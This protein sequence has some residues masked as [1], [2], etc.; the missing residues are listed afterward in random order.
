MAAAVLLIDIN[1]RLAKLEEGLNQA[2]RR[3]GGFKST[4]DS[5]GNSLKNAFGAAS[6]TAA[7]GKFVLLTKAA[8]DSADHL[9]DLS[10]T[11]GIAVETLGGIGFAA[12]Q[13]GSSLDAIVGPIGKLNLEIAKAAQG[14]PEAAATFNALK[15]SVRDGTGEIKNAGQVLV[16]IAGKFETFK[17]GPNKAALAN[18]LFKKGFAELVP[19]LNEGSDALRANIAYFE[20]YSGLTADVAQKADKFNDEL[21]KV[22]LLTSAFFRH[23][24]AELLPTLTG[25]AQAMSE[26]KEKNGGFRDEAAKTAEVI[27]NL[28]EW[29]FTGST[30]FQAFAT[31]LGGGAAQLAAIAVGDFARARK[32]GELMIEDLAKVRKEREAFLNR[33]NNPLPENGPKRPPPINAPGLPNSDGAKKILD[34]Q[35]KAFEDSIRDE[36]KL[37]S[38]RERFLQTYYADD[39][40]SIR[41]FFG[42]RQTIIDLALAKELEAYDGEIAA[43]T[44]GTDRV[45]AE[46]DIAAAI[47]KRADAQQAAAT[48]SVGLFFEERRALKA[49]KED[50]EQTSIRLLDLSGDKVGAALANFDFGN[51]Q[52]TLRINLELGSPDADTRRIAEISQ[53]ALETE[54]EQVKVQAQLTDGAQRFGD[55]LEQV[56]NAQARID[57]A[58]STGSL[59]ELEALRATGDANTAR[60]A[61]LRQ[62][63]DAY[64]EIAD[65]SSDPRAQL[66]ADALRL[67]IEQ[68]AAAGDLVAKK[69]NDVFINSFADAIESAT[70][71]GAKL[72]DILKNLEKSLVSGIS[73]IASQNIAETIFKPENLGGLGKIFGGL[74]G[75]KPAEATGAAALTGAGTTLTTAGTLLTTA[76]TQLLAAATAMQASSLAS[77]IGGGFPGFGGGFGGGSLFGGFGDAFGFPGF[78]TGTDFAP[79]GLAMVGE[80]GRELVQLPR[81]SRVI[82]NERLGGLGKSTTIHA[83]I[84]INMPAGST[85]RTANQTG[86]AVYRA[87]TRAA[88]RDG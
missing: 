24:S 80:R 69:F 11:T 57:I 10:K 6:V 8:I 67:K 7:V 71:K 65:K 77:S 28:A 78:A 83:P 43:S 52:R 20:K 29:A 50:L 26:A 79:G 46:S 35:I 76:A 2:N 59:T 38:D 34:A 86:V 75:G 39:E 12:S 88:R 19:L 22:N 37:L 16:E 49:F 58:R 21:A 18:A 55:V 60:I 73:K 72:S 5:L 44:S 48:K 4:V 85:S 74:F 31:S 13:A 82:P 61:Q 62:I 1:A 84:T 33:V 15:I 23:L 51:R 32:I 41:D 17:D 54:R 14:N 30:A 56:G 70:E 63:A 42:A 9:N 81:G 47:N 64:Q 53:H 87:I 3:L 27:K 68:L 25:Y 36:Q 45:K 66:A 40:L